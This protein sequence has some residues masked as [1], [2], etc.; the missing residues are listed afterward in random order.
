MNK[1]ILFALAIS[2][3]S[4]VSITMNVTV[5]DDGGTADSTQEAS[6]T[7]TADVKADIPIS[8]TK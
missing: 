7:P 3:Y 8:L 6:Q 4:C 2:M 5:S 1:L